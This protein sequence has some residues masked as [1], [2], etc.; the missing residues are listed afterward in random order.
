MQGDTQGFGYLGIGYPIRLGIWELGYPGGCN[1]IPSRV[2]ATA[3][4]STHPTGM[5]S[6][7]S[8]M[9]GLKSSVKYH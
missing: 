2:E 1:P 8:T 5:L 6:C 7:I 3:A 4:V 9:V